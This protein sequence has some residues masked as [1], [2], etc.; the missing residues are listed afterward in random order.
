MFSTL[1][2]YVW[3]T[4]PLAIRSCRPFQKVAGPAKN[5]KDMSIADVL[6]IY[7]PTKFS[8]HLFLI[9]NQLPLQ[10]IKDHMFTNIVINLLTRGL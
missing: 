7:Q 8:K 1:A 9:M 6:Y 5:S 3:T 4:G 2:K 10:C